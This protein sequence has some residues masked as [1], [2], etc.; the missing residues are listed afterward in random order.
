M[1]S[2][3]RVDRLARL[4]GSACTRVS[5]LFASGALALTACAHS[6]TTAA[7]PTPTP[8]GDA[9]MTAPNPDPRIGLKGGLWDAGQAE[10]NLHL[11]SNTRPSEGFVGKGNSDLAFIG[12]YV[13]QGGFNGVQIWDIS[14]AAHPTLK[15]AYVCPASQSDVSVY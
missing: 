7:G 3:L 2:V 14:N 9:S 8:Q 12:N 4:A 15:T 5:M 13:I 11:V 6:G 10:W 1:S